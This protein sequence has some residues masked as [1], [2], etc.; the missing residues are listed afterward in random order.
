MSW[1]EYNQLCKRVAGP[2]RIAGHMIGIV[3]F[4]SL[5]ERARRQLARL[6]DEQRQAVL[7]TL[8]DLR[9]QTDPAERALY[10]A[11]TNNRV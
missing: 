8:I 3:S 11:L 4:D 7:Q 2:L 1:E 5:V 10:V 6:D 9:D